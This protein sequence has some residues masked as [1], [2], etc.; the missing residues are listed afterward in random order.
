MRNKIKNIIGKNLS[1]FIDK[2]IKFINKYFISQLISFF[3]KYF[4]NFNV[5]LK[6]ISFWGS[7]LFAFA[8]WFY[9]SLNGTYSYNVDI[10]L[11]I[12]TPKDKAIE[13]KLPKTISIKV[14]GNGWDLFNLLNFNNNKRCY[15]DLAKLNLN[16]DSININKTILKKFTESIGNFTPLEVYPENIILSL[17]RV[18]EKDLPIKSKVKVIPNKQFILAQEQLLSPN[19]IRV[20]GSKKFIEKLEYI[21][22]EEKVYKNL[23]KDFKVKVKLNNID[24]KIKF[25]NKNTNIKI[26]Q[27]IDQLSE[28]VIENIPIEVIGTLK[29]EHRIYPKQVSL[30]VRGGINNILKLNYSTIKIKIDAKKIL[31]DVDGYLIPNII[32]PNN[33][34]VIDMYPKYI[35]HYVY[36]NELTLNK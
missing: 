26:T 4:K 14:K 2:I 27:K 15:L 36:Q 21:E 24:N 13:N 35:R 1:N 3:N 28:F 9:A 29:S 20:R 12:K 18:I 19:F 31:E 5:H 16:S 23:F 8:F 34:I 25:V 22:T 11:F 17:D 32:T 30:T 7:F 10:P 33:I 6:K